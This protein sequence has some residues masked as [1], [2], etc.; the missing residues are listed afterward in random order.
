[1]PAAQE[2]IVAA[3]PVS[4]STWVMQILVINHIY[5]TRV[6]GIVLWMHMKNCSEA[7]AV[8]GHD[9]SHLVVDRVGNLDCVVGVRSPD[10]TVVTVYL[11][12]VDI[13][14]VVEF[15]ARNK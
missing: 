3:R 11:M 12:D 9:G 5:F 4:P 6:R 8:G 13:Q 7:L 14:K 10:G 2:S 15:L 1:M